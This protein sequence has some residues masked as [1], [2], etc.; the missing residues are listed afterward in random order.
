MRIGILVTATWR[1]IDFFPPLL[2]TLDNFCPGHERTV[3]L[4]SDT[5]DNFKDVV[6]ID[7]DHTPFPYI[8][9][10]RYHRYLEFKHL[11]EDQDYL[12]HLDADMAVVSVGDEM[13][14]NLTAVRHPY[15]LS[16]GT[17]SWEGRPASAAFVDPALR[18]FYYCGGIQG[19][20]A[21]Q[22]LKASDILARRIDIDKA[23]GILAT[24]HDESHW[25]W[26]LANYPGSFTEL[27]AGYCY[28]DGKHI[29]FERKVTALNKDKNRYR[30]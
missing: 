1:Y 5:R 21:D 12:F 29:P 23:N 20:R 3:F 25:N 9:L 28:A 11:Y 10:E 8:T 30:Q 18:K 15:F 14:N 2:A 13:L 22:Y 24:W 6:K 7:I 16:E 4:F 27:N 17:G 26:F 19:G